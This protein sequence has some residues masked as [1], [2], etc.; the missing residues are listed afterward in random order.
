MAS[1]YCRFCR[2]YK[3]NSTEILHSVTFIFNST[4]KSNPSII[5]HSSKFSFLFGTFLSFRYFSH[6]KVV[7]RPSIF[8]ARP[9][10]PPASPR[11]G[12]GRG[13][14]EMG[15]GGLPD[16]FSFF[17]LHSPF[18]SSLTPAAWAG[19][20]HLTDALRPGRGGAGRGAAYSRQIHR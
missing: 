20:P 8:L 18:S 14:K 12:R 15:G 11:L 10:P 6:I 17:N 13:V 3:D 7:R 4:R 9:F 19:S 16:L 5:F 2:T 1:V